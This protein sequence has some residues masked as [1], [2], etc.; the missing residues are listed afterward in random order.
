MENLNLENVAEFKEKAIS[1]GME[2]A[3][4]L[5]LA[6][7]TLILGLW[8]IGLLCKGMTKAFNKKDYDASLQKYL[9]NL[10][11]NILKVILFISVIQMI[12][13]KTT[14]FVAVL[15]AAGLAVGLALQGSLSNFAGGVLILAFKPFKVG[16]YIKAQGLE[17]TVRSIQVFHTI[18]ITADGKKVILPNGDL[19]NGPIENYNSEPARRLHFEFGIGYAD[20]I[21]KAKSILEDLIVGDDRILKDPTHRVAITS[22]GDS[23]VGISTYMWCSPEQFWDVH[24]SFPEK[25]KKAFDENNVE[26]PFPQIVVHQASAS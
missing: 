8:V 16:D 18:L 4:K 17:G 19:S 5:V 11:K 21:D 25:V 6:I 3:P 10:T 14:S 26:I 24:F 13:V 12:G 9:I 7:L 22:H 15:G 1:M 23:S 20:D 2:Y